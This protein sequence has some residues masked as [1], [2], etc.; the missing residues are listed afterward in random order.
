MTSSAK[1]VYLHLVW[2]TI[3]R[4]ML[5]TPQIERIIHRCIVNQVNRLGC[6]TLAVNGMSDHIHLLVKFPTTVTIAQ[7]VQKA[8]GVSSKL[9]NENYSPQPPFRWQAGYGVYSVSRWDTEKIKNYV[10]NQ[11]NHHQS[12]KLIT[13][14]EKI[15]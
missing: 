4:E 1:A 12:M 2:T 6:T 13:Y 7:C 15:E 10:I 11:K 3:N 8:K 14:L 5:I 9:I